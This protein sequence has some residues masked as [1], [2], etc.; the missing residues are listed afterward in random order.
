MKNSKKTPRKSSSAVAHVSRGSVLNDLGFSADEMQS[1][2]I[3]AGLLSEIHRVVKNKGL[4]ARDLEKILDQPQPRVSELLRGKVS[5]M[6][7]E[8]LIDY[9]DKLGE[10]AFISFKPKKAA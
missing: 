5:T 8:K 3:K 9:L 7:I 4:K 1:L 6:S 2:K 10:E